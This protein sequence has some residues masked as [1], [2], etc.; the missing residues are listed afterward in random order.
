[1][2]MKLSLNRVNQPKGCPSYT[3]GP[4]RWERQENKLT[5]LKAQF[6][7]EKTFSRKILTVVLYL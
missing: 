1:M 3:L 6:D 5:E 2:N 4:E 7:W